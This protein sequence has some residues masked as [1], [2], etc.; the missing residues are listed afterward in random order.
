MTSAPASP[1]GGRGI[2]DKVSCGAPGYCAAAGTYHAASGGLLAFLAT[3]ANGTWSARALPG[4]IGTDTVSA[5]V[6]RAVSCPAAGDCAVVGDYTTAGTAHAFTLDKAGGT[7][8]TPQLVTGL[9]GL[10]QGGSESSLMSVSCAGPGDCTAGG[11]DL[12]A[13]GD[14]HPFLASESGG[15]WGRPR[16]CLATRR[17]RLPCRAATR[18]VR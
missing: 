7:W 16:P 9:A 15:T 17:C 4:T 14:L 18:P 11:G 13:A 6:I 3:E 1:A 2:L 8:G 5:S 10:Q 12:D